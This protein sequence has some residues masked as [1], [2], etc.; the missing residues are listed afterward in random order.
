MGITI[1]KCLDNFPEND[2]LLGIQK[3]IGHIMS[4]SVYKRPLRSFVVGL[5]SLI[6]ACEQW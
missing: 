2:I 4:M 1:S 5:H 6:Q 3:M